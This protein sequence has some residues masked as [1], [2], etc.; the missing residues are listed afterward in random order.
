MVPEIRLPRLSSNA[1]PPYSERVRLHVL[2]RDVIALLAHPLNLVSP[3]RVV[4][5]G[6]LSVSPLSLAG[7]L[8]T[9]R[10]FGT[11]SPVSRLHTPE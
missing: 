1:A 4:V 11:A 3:V 10:H 2:A 7:L 6:V 5:T 9:V 8:H